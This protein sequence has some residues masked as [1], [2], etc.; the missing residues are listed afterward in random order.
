MTM[1]P[2]KYHKPDSINQAVAILLENEDASVLAGGQTLIA[3]MKQRLASP[4]DLVDIRAIPGISGINVSNGVLTIGAGTTHEDVA[5]NASV[6][7]LCPALS[8]LAGKIGDPAV[9]HVGTIGGSLANNDPAADYPAGLLALNAIVKTNLRDIP[10]DKFFQGLFGTI[11]D[12]GEIITAVE[13]PPSERT[14]YIKF[15]QPAS[16]FSIVGV[17][18][19]L[20]NGR[21][22]VAI[23]GCGQEGVFRHTKIEEA[24]SVDWSSNSIGELSMATDDL[25]SDLHASAEY[26]AKLINV[27][28]KRAVE[29]S[30]LK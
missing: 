17:F 23:T 21:A 12:V 8:Y 27:L 10:I 6:R 20:T 9:R 16:R 15:S 18:V 3:T 22:R 5:T 4:S 29:A 28:S 2:T 14:A 24:L 11:L 25:I 7:A 1:Y 30:L 19:A 13:V 26:R